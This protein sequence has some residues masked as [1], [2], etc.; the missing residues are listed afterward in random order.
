M[1]PSFVPVDQVRDLELRPPVAG[2]LR[3]MLG[4]GARRY[5]PYL[6][7]LWRPVN[8]L[9]Q[10]GELPGV[11]YDPAAARENAEEDRT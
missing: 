8:G 2:Y 6:A 5:A 1:E 11:G 9:A 3:G 10:R 4:A 7:N